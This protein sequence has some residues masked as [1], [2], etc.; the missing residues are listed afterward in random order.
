MCANAHF[1]ARL[2]EAGG[3]AT[4]SIGTALSLMRQQH[5]SQRP[6]GALEPT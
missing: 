6:L 4:E 5:E 2:V 1:G 3:R